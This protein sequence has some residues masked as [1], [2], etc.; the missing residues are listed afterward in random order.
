MRELV[1]RFAARFLFLCLVGIPVGASAAVW[2]VPFQGTLDNVIE[3][4]AA[5]GDTIR[6]VGNGGAT[7]FAANIEI[8]KNLTIEGGWRADY[9]IRDP[10]IYVSVARVPPGGELFP[11]FRINGSPS[12]V[13]D[14]LRIHGGR[15][16]VFAEQG[17]NIVVRDCHFREQRNGELGPPVGGRPGGAVRMRGGS[18]LLERVT[19]DG[20]L[21]AFHGAALGLESVQQVVIRDS[22]ISNCATLP[23]VFG[24]FTPAFAGGLYV[25]DVGDLR[26]ERTEIIQCTSLARGGLGYIL[27]TPLT[28]VDCRF[29]RGVG[30]TAGGAFVIEQSPAISFSNCEFITNRAGQGGGLWVR[31]GGGLTVSGCTFQFNAPNPNPTDA[32]GGAIWLDSTPFTILDSTFDGNVGS[33]PC[34]RGG[35]VRLNSSGGTVTNTVFTGERALARG[36]AW[37]QIGGQTVFDRCRFEGN[38]SAIYGG[39]LQI[40]L[41]GTLDVRNSLFRGNSAQ[42]GG[43]VSAS[44][45]AA[46]AMNHCTLT[47]NSAGT[48]GAAVYLDTGALGR[49]ENSIVCCAPRGDLIHCS[50]GD[51]ELHATDV[52]NDDAVNLRPE[53]AGTCPDLIGVQGNIRANPLFCDAQGPGLELSGASPCIGAANDGGDMGWASQGCAAPAPLTV[54][55]ESWGAIKGRYRTR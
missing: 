25:A 36:A 37:S 44:F 5:P 40:E 21:T 26:M 11:V 50:S 23:F 31:A 4:F 35:G 45:T 42:L 28:A 16:G 41:A 55:E 39:A 29:E 18:L 14:G 12:V 2:R 20:T 24:I 8:D 33:D 49:I 38:S 17:A 7:Y 27:R 48:G 52:W 30:S 46:V 53:L 19:I 13:I 22:K 10:D 32:E 47:G 9:L 1:I 43:A 6:V 34:V 54:R 51:L 15:F 3:R